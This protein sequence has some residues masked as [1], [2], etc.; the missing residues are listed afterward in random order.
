MV[1]GSGG[2]RGKVGRVVIGVGE[3]GVGVL[4]RTRLA[5]SWCE[6]LRLLSRSSC[7]WTLT[8]GSRNRGSSSEV[9]D[10]EV[11]STGFSVLRS[12]QWGFTGGVRWE[13]VAAYSMVAVDRHASLLLHS[14]WVRTSINL[15]RSKVLPVIK[16]QVDVEEV[17]T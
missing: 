11:E 12:P 1:V 3:G 13:M 2:W 7:G 10:S 15:V 14:T 9:E 4:G 16:I 17:S 5:E 6:R 8:S